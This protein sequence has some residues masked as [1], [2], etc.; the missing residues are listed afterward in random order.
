[1][2]QPMHVHANRFWVLGHGYGDLAACMA[3]QPKD[4]DKP[5]LLTDIINVMAPTADQPATWLKFRGMI[6]TAGRK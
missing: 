6:R 3:F 1:M 5:V 2:K 4:T